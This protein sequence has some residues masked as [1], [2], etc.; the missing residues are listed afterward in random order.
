M[1][2]QHGKS[3]SLDIID[4][5]VWGIS[6]DFSQYSDPSVVGRLLFAA[7][8]H[9]VRYRSRLEYGYNCYIQSGV[10]SQATSPD[11]RRVKVLFRESRLERPCVTNE[12]CELVRGKST[13][14]QAVK[15]QQSDNRFWRWG[16]W[17]MIGGLFARDASFDDESA[18]DAKFWESVYQFL[19]VPEGYRNQ[20]IERIQ[21]AITG[22]GDEF[23]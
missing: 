18:F 19:S 21:A 6:L 11:W 4:R 5:P 1:D 15:I 2:K 20:I 14:E 10:A 17:E 8:H 23:R 7:V 22:F 12:M 9:A 3:V 13:S 16:F